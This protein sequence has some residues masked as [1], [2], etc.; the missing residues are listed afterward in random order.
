MSMVFSSSTVYKLPK[1]FPR[2]KATIPGWATVF[3]IPMH[4]VR[5]D[6]DSF[7]RAGTHG[8]Q[9][10]YRGRSKFF[11][12]RSYGQ[13]R[14]GSPRMALDAATQYLISIYRGPSLGFM[15]KQREFKA[16]KSLGAGLRIASKISR[17]KKVRE[18]FVEASALS[19]KFGPKRFYFGTENTV[20]EEKKLVAVEKAN[21]YRRKC[22]AKIRRE[23]NKALMPV[24]CS[25][26]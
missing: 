11:S 10:R 16:D 21:A 13:R 9:V 1:N 4:I 17:R 15:T 14:L 8:W 6:I 7:G 20:T 2:R 25:Q 3:V 5:I 26:K 23:K 12:D 24:P 22:I 19:E 18:F